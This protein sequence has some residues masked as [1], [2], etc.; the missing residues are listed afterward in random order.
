MIAVT[1][2][3]GIAQVSE[4]TGL[5]PSTI[6]FYEKCFPVYL[7]VQKT[8]DGKGG[9]R[10]YTPDDLQRIRE[11][12]RLLQEEGLTIRSARTRLEG[13]DESAAS[14]A[15]KKVRDMQIPGNATDLCKEIENSALAL[16]ESW[17]KA[18]QALGRLIEAKNE[19]LRLRLDRAVT[20]IEGS[21]KPQISPD[22]LKSL[23]DSVDNLRTSW[24]DA[25]HK[26]LRALEEVPSW[27]RK[28]GQS[29]DKLNSLLT[30]Q[31]AFR[32]EVKDH[33]EILAEQFSELQK[34]LPSEEG[35]HAFVPYSLEP[36]VKEEFTQ[37][38]EALKTVKEGQWR[39][40]QV[41]LDKDKLEGAGNESDFK[42]ILDHLVEENQLLRS[43]QS[44]VFDLVK[45]VDE[46]LNRLLGITALDRKKDWWHQIWK[47]GDQA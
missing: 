1:E 12:A 7:T 3:V 34:G 33:F 47:K 15:R 25:Q 24:L 31:E 5:P 37:V 39:L 10:L 32:Q 14:G 29:S 18:E 28:D 13:V 11:I 38:K 35:A 45:Q 21:S 36:D 22:V 19:D 2:P 9:R 41:L 6:R 40:L 43:Q 8:K 42:M 27:F 46:K 17:S 30:S 16:Q 44:M 4:A 23:R 20:A 26:I